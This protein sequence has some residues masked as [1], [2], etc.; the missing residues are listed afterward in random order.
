MAGDL[1]SLLLCFEEVLDENLDDSL[2]DDSEI[3]IFVTVS[4]FTR[5]N[6]NRTEGFFEVIV[7]TY[8]PDTFSSHFRMSR[9]T[10]TDLCCVIA[11]TG[12]IS[13]NNG[14]GR[15]PIPL[16]KQVLAFLWFVANPEVIRSVSDRFNVTLSSM[17]RIIHRVSEALVDLRQDYIKWPTGEYFGLLFILFFTYMVIYVFSDCIKQMRWM[18]SRQTSKP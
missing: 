16:E 1:R 8:A 18:K 11:R 9:G 13:L 17:D 4:T 10:F 14:F 5:Q 2:Y 7:P 3:V 15:Q 6:L 12:R